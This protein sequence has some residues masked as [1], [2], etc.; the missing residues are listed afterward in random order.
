ML[1]VPLPEGEPLPEREAL[2]EPLPLPLYDAL[3]LALP[4]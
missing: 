4:V 2:G 1:C 3:L